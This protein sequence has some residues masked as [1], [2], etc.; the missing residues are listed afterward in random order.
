MWTGGARVKSQFTS[1]EVEI[2]REDCQ[3]VLSRIQMDQ[4]T[5][6]STPC[7]SM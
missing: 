2:E 3:E 6:I 5:Q 7:L 4:G 1:S